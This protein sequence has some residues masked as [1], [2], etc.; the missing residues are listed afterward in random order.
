M[1]AKYS[2]TCVRC[3]S[4]FPAGAE[5]ASSSGGFI[6]W[7][8]APAEVT[9]RFVEP[10]KPDAQIPERKTSRFNERT[11][12]ITQRRRRHHSQRGRMS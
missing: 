2:G 6:E 4:R 7:R 10:S 8:C 1:I 11:F 3:G 5:I 12:K 9:V